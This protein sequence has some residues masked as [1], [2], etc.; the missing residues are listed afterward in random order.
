MSIPKNWNGDIDAAMNHFINVGRV[1][2]IRDES[3][4]MV[5]IEVP[6]EIARLVLDTYSK[7][8]HASGD[9]KAAIQKI[10]EQQPIRNF[11]LANSFNI[12]SLAVGVAQLIAAL[13]R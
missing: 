8:L 4:Q 3:N 9:E 6:S 12:A 1:L 2:E 5:R 11:L 10:E 7:S 13:T